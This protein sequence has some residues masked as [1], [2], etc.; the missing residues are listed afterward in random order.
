LRTAINISDKLNHELL[1][2]PIVR[3]ALSTKLEAAIE[4]CGN[5]MIVVI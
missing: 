4:T 2:D 5:R 1:I 3:Q